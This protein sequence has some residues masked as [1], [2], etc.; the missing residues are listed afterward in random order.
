MKNNLTK[1]D[2]AV[3]ISNEFGFSISYSKK[4]V[5][6]FIDT[7]IEKIKDNNLNIQNLG[8]FKIRKK[9]ERVG[10]NP[11]TNESF[12]IKERFS[13]SFSAS[14]NLLLSLNKTK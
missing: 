14:R 11:K 12:V 2:M 3:N 13:L 5:E 8:V 1:N 6:D 4:I 7:L 10:R 9:K